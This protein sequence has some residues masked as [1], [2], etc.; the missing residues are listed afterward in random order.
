MDKQTCRER[1]KEMNCLVVIPTYNNEGT[2]LDVI[3]DVLEYAPE[4]LVVNDGSTDSTSS[5]LHGV[6]GIRRSNTVATEARE[7]R[8]SWQSNMRSDTA[9]PIC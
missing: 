5:L 9:S 4:L 6:E 2:V 3:R 1:L 7:A 8:S